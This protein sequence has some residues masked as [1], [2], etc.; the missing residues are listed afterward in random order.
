[1]YVDHLPQDSSDRILDVIK[2][3][4]LHFNIQ[5]T[6]HSVYITIRKKFVKE[7]PV[8][9]SNHVIV[10]QK[11]ASLEEANSNIR[12]YLEEEIDSHRESRNIVKILEDKLENAEAQFIEESSKFKAEKEIFEK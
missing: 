7:S 6:P 1:M 4:N 5:E 10:E 12:N 2:S 9:M 11:L 3:S 8:K